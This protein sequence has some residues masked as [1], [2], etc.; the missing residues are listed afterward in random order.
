MRSEALVTLSP[1]S[2]RFLDVKIHNLT[3]LQL[4]GLEQVFSEEYHFEVRRRT[5]KVTKHPSPQ[6]QLKKALTDFTYDF[7]GP[8][9]LYLIYY[10]GHGWTGNSPG[11]LNL[12]G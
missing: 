9:T 3:L 2:H 12:S 8:H 4:D 5:L 6:K 11:N 10:A 7:D 1:E